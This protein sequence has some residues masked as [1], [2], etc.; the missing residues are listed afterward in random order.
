[1]ER[2]DLLINGKWVPAR[3]G[4]TFS[5]YDPAR[6]E[7][8]A[9]VAKA[10]EADVADAALAARK[11]FDEG[12]WPRMKASERARILFRLADL[13]RDNLE[14]IAR[15]E[16]MNV[17][18]P[19]SD[20][21]DETGGGASCFEY[22]AGAATKF[23]GETI[24]VSNRGFDFTLREPCGVVAAIVPWNFPF[25]MTAWKVAP[26]L[27]TGNTVIL[28]P[29]SYTPLS[30]LCL[31]RL[32][33]EA[34]VPEGVLNLI[35][36]PG[37]SAGT[38]I[39][40]HPAVNKITFTGETTTGT[41]IMKTAAEDIK[42]VSLELGGKSPNIVFA[43]AD[44]EKAGRASV[45]SV[46]G[47]CGQD[48][49]ARSR[50]FVEQS[51]YDKFVNA[52]IDQTSKTVIGDP[53]DDATQIGPMVSMKQRETVC[54]YIEIGKEEGATLAYGGEIL[55]EGQYAKGSYIRPA[56]FT[57][58]KNSM[59]TC[60][61]EIFGPVLSVIPFT[62]ADE[63]IRQVNDSP[64]GLSGS[65]WTTNL[66]RALLTARRVKSGVLSVNTNSSVYV[67]A[68]FG[69]YKKS[70]IGRDLGMHTLN[71]FT[72]IKNVFINIGEDF[73]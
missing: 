38:A 41:A 60:Q 64:Y 57:N 70:G 48:C 32:A 19:I 34:G 69:G 52:F 73:A 29:A 25:L 10:D 63:M 45:L 42:R 22:Y 55:T 40:A 23:F 56:V 35:T 50:A 1:M 4:E 54:K 49:C 43:D 58:A 59:R 21:R 8:I 31:V 72:E 37:S 61:E 5:V 17:G 71:N 13:I 65:I 44:V 2:Y 16:A 66:N 39:V 68:P 14:E 30:A 6:T 46:F 33:L 24:P 47:N 9:E 20:S 18:K 12:P 36:G 11:A 15:Y 67:E 53:L 28:K 7:V 27:A 62:D 26:A 51:V 3:S